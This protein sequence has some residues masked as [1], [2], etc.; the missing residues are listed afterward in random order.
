MARVVETRKIKATHFGGGHLYSVQSTEKIENGYIG[1]LGD[2]IKGER[3]IREFKKITDITSS[4]NE[5][6]LIAQPEIRYDYENRADKRRLEDFT[7]EDGATVR[8]YTLAVG[9][10]FGLS[11]ESI[12]AKNDTLK[13]GNKV[14]LKNNSFELEEKEAGEVNDSKFVLNIE[15]FYQ[16]NKMVQVAKGKVLTPTKMVI[17]R[18]V[19]NEM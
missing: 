4:G 14:V 12:K 9:D 2:L 8:A 16:M 13:A 15:G 1:V 3:E 17:L 19:K 7:I 10:E 6:V 5:I 18:V 11:L